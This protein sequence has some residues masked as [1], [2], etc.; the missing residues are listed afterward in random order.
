VFDA[1]VMPVLTYGL[2]TMAITRKFAKK[3]Q[4]AM[5]RRLTLRDR[6]CSE[7]IRRR[8]KV[9][10]ILRLVAQMK[11]R[12]AGH[13]ARQDDP[14]AHRILVWRPRETKRRRYPECCRRELD[15]DC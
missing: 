14:Q 5:E 2:E 8:T 12:W 10:D 3:L 11:G 9:T 15:P 4:R 7:E 1:C 6:I 13:V